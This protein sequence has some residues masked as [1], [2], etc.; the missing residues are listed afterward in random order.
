M[1]SKASDLRL[2]PLVDSLEL[3]AALDTTL[4]LWN[5]MR[6]LS[7][8]ALQIDSDG[9]DLFTFADSC[10]LLASIM[11]TKSKDSSDSATNTS[12]PRKVKKST[13]TPSSR[14]KNATNECQ[15][16]VTSDNPLPHI[17]DTAFEL[18]P[19]ESILAGDVAE[20]SLQAIGLV[21]C[22]PTSGCRA[23]AGEV[24]IGIILDRPFRGK[25]YGRKAVE[26]ILEWAFENVHFRRVQAAVI[27]NVG[28]DKSIALFTQL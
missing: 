26:L 5:E 15:P 19:K 27:D 17:T 28:R 10:L 12:R 13:E 8:E 1:Q 2:Y 6:M 23:I 3:E 11:K 14:R 21:Y 16:P 24:S 4:Q 22:V 18:S 20:D 25:G 9:P 7:L